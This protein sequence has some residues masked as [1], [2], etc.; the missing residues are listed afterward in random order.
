[1]SDGFAVSVFSGVNLVMFFYEGLSCPHCH[2]AFR[3]SDDIVACPVCGAPH[4]RGCWGDAGGC[5]C[6]DDHGTDRQWSRERA[7]NEAKE[8]KAKA[9]DAA[10]AASSPAADANNCPRCGAI[11]S[12]YAEMCY[13]C[14]QTLQAKDWSSSHNRTDSADRVPPASFNE[15]TP[16]HTPVSPFGGVDPKA[17][18]DGEAAEDYAAVT[19]TN[20]AYYLPR[21]QHLARNDSRIAWNW[22]AFLLA[23]YWLMF[24]KLHLAG[25]LALLLDILC[26]TAANVVMMTRLPEVYVE[27]AAGQAVLNYAKWMELMYTDTRILLPT[28]LIGMLGA[29]MIL[30]HVM[31]GLFGTRLYMNDCRRKIQKARTAYPEGYR[32]QLS[33]LG[34]TSFVLGALAILLSQSLP[35]VILTFLLL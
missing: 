23:P 28:L 29:T 34:G 16:F 13:R 24:R 5:A 35:S 25:A 15:Y 14:G 7:L 26:T 20:T 33:V 3:E 17:T 22:S 1:M 19:R 12:P 2:R 32:A 11:N 30:F 27:N 21:F 18:L 31:I 9:E 6:R 8:E 10:S 4:H